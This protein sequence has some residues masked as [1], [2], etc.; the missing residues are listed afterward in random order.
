MVP[1]KLVVGPENVRNQASNDFP[2]HWPG[3]DHEWDLENFKNVCAHS[4]YDLQP[5]ISLRHV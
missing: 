4:C 2:G 1:Q 5:A 3:E